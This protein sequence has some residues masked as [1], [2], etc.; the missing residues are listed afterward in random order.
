MAQVSLSIQGPLVG[1]FAFARSIPDADAARIV[2]AY[3]GIYGPIIEGGTPR[4]RTPQEIVDAIAQGF[5]SGVLAN[6][7]EWEQQQAASQID[8][9]PIS[10]E[11]P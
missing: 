4:P 11:E 3:G 6:V 7:I 5:L 9:P 2:R 10:V 1:N 8:I